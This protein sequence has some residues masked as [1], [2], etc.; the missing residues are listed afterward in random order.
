V[1]SFSFESHILIDL[2][3]KIPPETQLRDQL[4]MHLV[5]RVLFFDKPF[6]SV[7]IIANITK[8]EPKK[9]QEVLS[10][11]ELERLLFKKENQY[12]ASYPKFTMPF[13]DQSKSLLEALENNGIVP[14]F[15]RH[16]SQ[17]L[18]PKAIKKLNIPFS[19]DVFVHETR[20]DYYGDGIPFAVTY[21]YTPTYI[22]EDIDSILENNTTINKYYKAHTNTLKKEYAMDSVIYPSYV[23]DIFSIPYGKAG[24]LIKSDYYDDSDKLVN[25]YR[26]YINGWY[27]VHCSQHKTE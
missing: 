9:I 14:S 18:D 24:I 1:K 22:I 16:Q 27:S 26:G 15:K 6:P 21:N 12:F 17:I 2:R 5:D 4:R 3:S 23:A 20:I 25:S 11:L 8:I 10:K 13:E 19:K 7:E